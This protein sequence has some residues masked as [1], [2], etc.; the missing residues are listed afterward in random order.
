MSN[1]G[2]NGNVFILKNEIANYHPMSDVARWRMEKQGRFPKRVKV[3]LKKVA[4]N[5]AAVVE[6]QQDPEAWIKKNQPQAAPQS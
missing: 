5:R 6:W 1:Q 2:Q 4:W 3:G